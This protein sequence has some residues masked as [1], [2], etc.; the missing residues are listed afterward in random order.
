MNFRLTTTK[1]I[2]SIII[3]AILWILVFTVKF[4]TP[5]KIIQEFLS[6]HDLN[7]LLSGG[8]IILFVIEV[9]I[10]YIILSLLQRRRQ[11]W[12]QPIKPL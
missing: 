3:P 5:P 10:L 6:L 1:G 4:I 8:N 7:N 11:H 12:N 2:L 9:V